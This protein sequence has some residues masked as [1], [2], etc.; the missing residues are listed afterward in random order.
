M[1]LDRSV[2][3]ARPLLVTAAAHLLDEALR[4]AAV[5]GVDLDVAADAGPA[6]DRWSS[7]PL[8]LLGV[9]A[10]PGCV[11]QRLPRRDGVVLLSDDLDDARIWQV[12]VE[13]GAAQVAVLPGDEDA[14]LARLADA[15]EGGPGSG[16]LVAVVAVVGGRGG[17]GATTLACALAVTAAR[18]G[19]RALLVD[20]DPLGGGVDLVSGRR[21]S[22]ACAGRTWGRRGAGCPRRPWWRPCRA[23]AACSSVLGPRCRERVHPDAVAAVL[24]AARRAYDLVVLDLP[25]RRGRRG[26]ARPARRRPRAARRTG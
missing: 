9:D 8:V 19:E 3:P 15:A 14:V 21:R 10:V 25:R 26:A 2:P 1:P 22:G 23:R 13:V 6:R 24:Q 16:T 12:G 5:A 20:A 4:L 18:A 7:A 11:R 17:A